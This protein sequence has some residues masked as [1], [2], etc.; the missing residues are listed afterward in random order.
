MTANN[1]GNNTMDPTTLDSD[2]LAE[3]ALD[4]AAATIQDALGVTDGGFAG[5]YFAGDRGDAIRRILRGYIA[6]ERA[7]LTWQAA[8]PHFEGGA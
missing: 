5:L 8:R 7:H 4:A 2:T 3:A 6:A 1:E